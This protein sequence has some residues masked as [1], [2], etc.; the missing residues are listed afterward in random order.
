MGRLPLYIRE[1]LQTDLSLPNINNGGFT[2]Y[3][4][5]F[6][7]QEFKEEAFNIRRMLEHFSLSLANHLDQI[8][9]VKYGEVID[10]IGI[11]IGLDENLKIWIYEV[12]WRPGCPP[13]FYLEL[14]VVVHSIQ[15][16]K[17]IAEN[18]RKIK[19]EIR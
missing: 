6:L 9:M 18:Q 14:D 3:L 11:D 7:Q 16:A 1:L 8:Q 15:Y 19:N 12:N 2:N 5:P 13:A 10:E 4:D 17:F